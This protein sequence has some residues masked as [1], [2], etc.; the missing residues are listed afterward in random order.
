MERIDI[1]ALDPHTYTPF[2]PYFRERGVRRG[3]ID[4]TGRDNEHR[5]TVHS[6][7]RVG[8]I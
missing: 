8:F 1:H 4:K 5:V 7:P 2:R 3:V 6:A